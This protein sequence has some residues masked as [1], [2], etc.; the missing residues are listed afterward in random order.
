[1][2]ETNPL[3]DNEL[4]ENLVADYLRRHPH[5]LS[6]H[7]DVLTAQ[8]IPHQPGRGVASLVER[9]VRLLRERNEALDERLTELLQAAR[10][11]ERV[12]G[13]LV[14]LACNLLE[15]D[16]LDAVL[17]LVRD[18]LLSEFSADVVW[19]RLLDRDGA[20]ASRDP[21]RFIRPDAPELAPFAEILEHGQPQCGGITPQALADLYPG[22]TSVTPASAAVVPLTAGN[23]LGLVILGSVSDGHFHPEMG[24]HFLG[25]LGALVT[26]A[27]ASHGGE[28]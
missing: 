21:A 5:F 8:Q 12:A 15:A 23:P 7:P 3:A 28:R 19:I 14:E 20:A 22:D 24:T 4:D 6:H 1:M 26:A 25:Q 11:N 9:Q 27:V 13:R 17:A 16:S 10:E 2:T 18:T